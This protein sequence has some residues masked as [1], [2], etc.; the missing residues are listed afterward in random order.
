MPPTTGPRATRARDAAGAVT[1][2]AAVRAFDRSDRDGLLLG[3]RTTAPARRVLGAAGWLGGRCAEGHR[4]GA[5]HPAHGA[6]DRRPPPVQASGVGA[7]RAQGE[8]SRGGATGTASMDVPRAD[9]LACGG[10]RSPAGRPH[11]DDPDACA[12]TATREPT[13]LRGGGSPKRVAGLGAQGGPCPAGVPSSRGGIGPRPR[14]LIGGAPCPSRSDRRRFVRIDG[15]GC[16]R[17]RRAVRRRRPIAARGSSVGPGGPEPRGLPMPCPGAIALPP[18]PMR[19]GSW[20]QGR[21]KP[22]GPGDRAP[23]GNRGRIRRPRA[24]ASRNARSSPARAPCRG[25]RGSCARCRA[26]RGAGRTP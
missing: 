24:R 4:L 8:R 16:L 14:R 2:A 5:A 25:R 23:R 17:I 18:W 21:A 20:A 1:G 15:R 13:R 10:L 12:C 9:R 7:A 19:V 26:P 3:A 22:P 11:V 6:T